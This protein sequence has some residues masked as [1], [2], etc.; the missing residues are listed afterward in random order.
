MVRRRPGVWQT[1]ARDV[2][3]DHYRRARRHL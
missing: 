3:P 2:R 1:V